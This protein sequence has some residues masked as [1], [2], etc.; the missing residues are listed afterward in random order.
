MDKNKMVIYIAKPRGK[1][2][3]LI[4]KDDETC[5]KVNEEHIKYGQAKDFNDRIK[6]YKKDNDGDVDMYP[7]VGYELFTKAQLTQ[8]ET[9]IGRRVMKYRIKNPISLGKRKNEGLTEWC[10]GLDKTELEEII[11]DEFEKIMKAIQA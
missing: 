1:R 9:N 10:K 5:A 3:R 11:K 8:L 2:Y 7:V 4:S 6:K